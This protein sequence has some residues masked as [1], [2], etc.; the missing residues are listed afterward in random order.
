MTAL[1]G[2]T[3]KSVAVE[4]NAV[5]WARGAWLLCPEG[6]R[7]RVLVRVLFL[8]ERDE[9]SKHGYLEW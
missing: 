3:H 6:Q 5:K 8:T 1:P 4:L 7:E 9:V 2:D